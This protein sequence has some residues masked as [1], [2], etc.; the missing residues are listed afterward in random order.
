MILI[1]NVNIMK[2]RFPKC[3]SLVENF[4]GTAQEI[5]METTKSANLTFSIAN[6]SGKMY[7]HSKYDP[8]TEAEKVVANFPEINDSKHVFFYGIG[9]GYHIEAFCEKY[10]KVSF[11]VY[12]PNLSIFKALLS[13]KKIEKWNYK[14]LRNLY[15]GEDFSSNLKHFIDVVNDEVML[16]VLPSYER[17]FKQETSEFLKE[18]RNAVFNKGAAIVANKIFSKRNT[19]NTVINLPK[20]ISTPNLIH[21]QSPDFHGKPAILVAAG[22]SLDQEYENL[23]AIKEKGSAYI[24]SVGSAINSLIEQGI[25]PDAACSYDGSEKNQHVF[26]KVIEQGITDIPLIYGSTVGFETLQKYPGEMANFLVARDYLSSYVLKRMDGENLEFVSPSKSIA[27]ITLEL[28]Y[29][30]GCHPIILVGQNL[31]Y[32]EERSYAQGMIFNNELTETQKETAIVVKD[33]QGND[34]LTNRGLDTFR[35]EMEQVISQLPNVN[36]IN[37]TKRGAHI[38]GTTFIPLD[39]VMKESLPQERVVGTEWIHSI[40][41]N[42]SIDYFNEQIA[43]LESE[44]NKLLR[45]IGTFNDLIEAMNKSIQTLNSKQ[46]SKLFNQFDSN[47][48]KMQENVYYHIFVQPMNILKFESV[49]KMFAEVR[50]GQNDFS[51]AKRVV[52]EFSQY[53]EECQADMETVKP[54]LEQSVREITTKDMNVEQI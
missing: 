15:A 28:L 5:Q 54:L 44:Y 11:S 36:V 50:F 37:T 6:E 52:K 46:L 42:Y 2:N 39:E 9:L 43:K 25:Y 35:K 48:D 30:L 47:F 7:I 14:F 18:F 26:S 31:A 10:P 19:I 40:T 17:A 24:F 33:V 12:E 34:V 1:D 20:T 45:I 22:P 16:I 38:E 32:L 49:M 3:W 23:R 51:K 21:E 8:L 29:K 41:S 4:E 53:L 27:I 13:N